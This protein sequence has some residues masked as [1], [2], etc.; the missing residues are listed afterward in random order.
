MRSSMR[1]RNTRQWT[2]APR[3]LLHPEACAICVVLTI[4]G[5]ATTNTTRFDSNRVRESFREAARQTLPCYR[6]VAEDPKYTI[7]QSRLAIAPNTM[8]TP[9]QLVDTDRP[10]PELIQLGMEWYA[11][12]QV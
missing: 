2:A 3:D 12:H 7:L 6:R 10:T 5:G 11:D 1:L 8:P 4:L 9:P